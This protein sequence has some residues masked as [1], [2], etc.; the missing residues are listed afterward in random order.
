VCP[1]LVISNK[2]KVMEV[3]KE[4]VSFE[5]GKSD[6]QGKDKDA[7]NSFR[8]WNQISVSK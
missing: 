8:I 3:G 1:K 2:G 5:A 6:R 4:E 7:F